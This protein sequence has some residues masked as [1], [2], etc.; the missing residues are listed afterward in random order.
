MHTQKHILGVTELSSESDEKEPFHRRYTGAVVAAVV[1][2][3]L[4]LITI[5]SSAQYKDNIGARIA[6]GVGAM[7]FFGGTAFVIGYAVT[8]LIKQKR[9][10]TAIAANI[11]AHPPQSPDPAT[12]WPD[13]WQAESA[14]GGRDYLL[15]LDQLDRT[16]REAASRHWP[17][18]NYISAVE[19]ASRAVYATLQ[20]R[21]GLYRLSESD[22][23][24]HLYSDK[25]P[26][27]GEVRL[28]FPGDRST[29]T[30]ISRTNGAKALGVA[31]FSGIRNLAAHQ[32]RPNWT[33]EDAFEYLVM[34]SVLM[35]WTNECE[36]EKIP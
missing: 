28:R 12:S 20:A 9:K 14:V 17:Y 6:N 31:C 10:F 26:K 27:S 13:R 32:H 2:G 3:L 19:D 21:S 11:G 5:A 18:G 4:A 16:V 22:L 1:F 7:V 29:R 8:K 34:F 33:R 30:W 35:R 23:I 15:S 36:V 24:N 25:P